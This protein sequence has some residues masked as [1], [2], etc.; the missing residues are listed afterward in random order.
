MGMFEN[1][2]CVYLDADLVVAVKPLAEICDDR[3]QQME[4]EMRVE[5]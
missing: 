4:D 5:G 3:K 1:A 2:A